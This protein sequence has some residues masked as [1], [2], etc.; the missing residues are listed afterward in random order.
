MGNSAT[1]TKTDF[2]VLLS[3]FHESMSAEFLME[4]TSFYFIHLLEVLIQIVTNF[5]LFYSVEDD[6]ILLQT[7]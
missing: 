6:F 5:R 2:E 1:S 7:D 3:F 4:E